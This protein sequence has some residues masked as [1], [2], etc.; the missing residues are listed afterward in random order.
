MRKLVVLVLISLFLA[1]PARALE[2]LPPEVPE[3]EAALMPEDTEDFSAGLRMLLKNALEAAYP[4]LSQALRTGTVV[5]CAGLLLCVLQSFSGGTKRFSDLASAVF[6]ASILLQTTGSLIRLGGDTVTRLSEYGKLF[7]PVMTAA[8]AAQGRSVTSAALYAGTAAFDL[9]L[10]QLIA[11]LLLPMTYLF[12]VLAVAHSALEQNVMKKLRDLIKWIIS[13]S[14]KTL[15]TIYTTYISITGVV[16]GTTDAAAL[17][18]AK[19]TISTAV[20][21]VGGILSDA[22]ETVLVS[23]GLMKNAAGIYG[24]LAFL[25]IFLLP[26]LRI[27]VHYAVL[28]GTAAVSGLFCSRAISGLLEDFSTAMGFLLAMTASSCLLLLISTVCFLKGAG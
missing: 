10:T 23:A 15:L 27:G 14:L 20:P 22:S 5:L 16:S 19:L 2:I 3:E 26:F 25:S 1:L 12:L 7:L 11:Q 28:K 4:A 8:L 24:I 6:S 9:V 21:V 13:W 17:K 18:A